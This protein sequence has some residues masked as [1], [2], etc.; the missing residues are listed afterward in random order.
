MLEFKP[1]KHFPDA[2]GFCLDSPQKWSFP[3]NTISPPGG[4]PGVC[5]SS[6]HHLSAAWRRTQV[7]VSTVPS[8]L[9]HRGSAEGGQ[10]EELTL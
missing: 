4:C 7:T 9:I 3:I 10:L 6:L 8:A 1:T 5:S 2:W